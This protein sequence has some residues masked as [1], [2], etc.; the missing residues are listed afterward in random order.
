MERK[1]TT[2][3]STA[4]AVTCVIGAGA[5]GMPSEAPDPRVHA[6]SVAPS[7]SPTADWPVPVVAL[8]RPETPAAAPAAE[9]APRS[10]VTARRPTAVLVG[11]DAQPC[12]DRTVQHAFVAAAPG[13]MPEFTPCTD[14]EVIDH[15][16]VG[17]ASFG[18]IG[19]SLSSREVHAGLRQVRLGVELFAV[20]VSQELS[21]RSLTRTQVRQIF[22]GQITHWQQLGFDGGPI[23]AVAPSDRALAERA[24]RTLIPGDDFAAGC[25]RA[26]DERQFVDLLQQHRGAIGI[27]RVSSAP[28][29][30]GIKLLQID[31]SPPTMEAYGYGTY[32]YGVPLHLVT[33]G[34]PAGAAKEFAAFVGSADGRELLARSLLLAQ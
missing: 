6:A 25:L 4:L 18:L 23:V 22:T 13:L 9:T 11:R 7:A 8:V 1:T 26:P 32:P 5:V 28:R 27:V 3:V 31:W 16:L 15:L 2:I 30:A 19:G 34:Q 17:R 33:T 10:A 21:V 29:D 12:I 20:A 14:R 24:A